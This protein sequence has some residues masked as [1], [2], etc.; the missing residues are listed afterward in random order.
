MLPYLL[1]Y[2]LSLIPNFSVNA[3]VVMM[4]MF[5]LGFWKISHKGYARVTI[6]LLECLG[7][8]LTASRW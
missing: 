3:P 7:G 8:M 1:T 2:S 5:L 4:R 6:E